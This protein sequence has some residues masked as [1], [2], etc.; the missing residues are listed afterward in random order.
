MVC[1]DLAEQPAFFELF[2]QV[3]VCFCPCGAVLFD[4]EDD[5]VLEVFELNDFDFF[6][7]EVLCE[8]WVPS[9][10]VGGGCYRVFFCNEAWAVWSCLAEGG[11]GGGG[12]E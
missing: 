11:D 7:R 5:Q 8:A 1:F 6:F 2:E 10:C 4:F 9:L 12:E 3:M